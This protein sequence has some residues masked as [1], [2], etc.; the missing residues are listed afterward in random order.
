MLDALSDYERAVKAL[1]SIR[2]VA[3]TFEPATA[4]KIC[5][6]SLYV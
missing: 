4:V 1:D 6:H 3:G 2:R 5:A